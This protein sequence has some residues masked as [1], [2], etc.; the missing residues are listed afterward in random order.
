MVTWRMGSAPLLMAML[1][2]MACTV[3][4]SSDITIDGNEFYNFARGGVFSG[5][6]NLTVSNNEIYEIRSDG[7]DFADVDKVLIQDNYIHDFKPPP[8]RA[9]TMPT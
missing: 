4:K 1:R 6:T 3:S 2:D 8:W 7:L 5:V 9:A